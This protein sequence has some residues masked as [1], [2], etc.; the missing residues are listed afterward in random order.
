MKRIL[1][2]AL[3]IGIVVLA[4]SCKDKFDNCPECMGI[5]YSMNADWYISKCSSNEMRLKSNSQNYWLIIEKTET[6]STS[7]DSIKNYLMNYYEFKSI[8]V[9]DSGACEVSGFHAF[10]WEN[11]DYCYGRM[12]R[13]Y[14]V[15]NDG[16]NYRFSYISPDTAVFYENKV[17]FESFMES[18]VIK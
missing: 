14:L 5:D 16:W 3:V 2:L 18:V 11:L 1:R 12:Q 10:R 15:N 9:L 13:I 7:I 17:L 8:E 6:V 4:V